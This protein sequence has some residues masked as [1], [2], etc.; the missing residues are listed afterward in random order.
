M[1]MKSPSVRFAKHQ[2]H[3]R[4][5]R[6]L[7][8]RLAG[9]SLRDFTEEMDITAA[10]FLGQIT[11]CPAYTKIND[12]TLQDLNARFAG[13]E[14]TVKAAEEVIVYPSPSKYKIDSSI[15]DRKIRADALR[16]FRFEGMNNA[17]ARLR[18]EEIDAE[19]MEQTIAVSKS[20]GYD[21]KAHFIAVRQQ[22]ITLIAKQLGISRR[23]AEMEY[24]VLVD[25]TLLQ[26]GVID[27]TGAVTI[28]EVHLAAVKGT[29]NSGRGYDS[30]KY[31]QA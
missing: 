3:Q 15:L 2:I 7:Q 25:R 26:N 18:L 9:Y 17:D 8:E 29:C 24:D 6:L 4:P 16:R 12:M 19:A 27:E 10:D 14:K 20:R 28:D 30:A 23:R 31:A 11:H 5:G 1:N 21:V 22:A 13:R